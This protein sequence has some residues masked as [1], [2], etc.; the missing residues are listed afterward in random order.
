VDAV[1]GEPLY[2]SNEA[3]L[4]KAGLA[5]KVIQLN[6]LN[7]RVSAARVAWSNAL[8]DRNLFMYHHRESLLN[9]TR[10][11]KKYVRA[12]FGHNSVQYARLDH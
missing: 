10:A 7:Q 5:E 3:H 12:I 6:A 2:L 11:V 9:T 1:S 4:S 8:I